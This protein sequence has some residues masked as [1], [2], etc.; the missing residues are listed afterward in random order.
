MIDSLARTPIIIIVVKDNFFDDLNSSYQ[1]VKSRNSTL[2]LITNC[3]DDLETEGIDHIV[4]IPKE[5]MLSSFY[6]VFVGQIIAYYCSVLK[7]FNPD[8]PRQLSK[9]ITTK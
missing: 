9:E 1:Q 8:K 2:I 6:A 4:E 5:G 7:G 3:K